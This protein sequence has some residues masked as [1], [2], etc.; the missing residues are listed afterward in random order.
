MPIDMYAEE[1]IAHYE[2]PHN[3]GEMKNPSVSMHEHNPL[4]G[5]DLTIY[6]KIDNGRIEDVRFSGSGCAISMA[7]A[8]MLTDFIKG[9]KLDDID[10]MG[11]PT[12][13]ELLGIDPGPARL[14]CATLSLRTVKEASF[15]YQRKEVDSKT[16][17]L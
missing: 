5:D 3:K 16:R 1:I 17:E 6:L 13:I 11:L 4:C 2:K 10:K 9:K 15:L 8:S 12:I 14:K 7:S